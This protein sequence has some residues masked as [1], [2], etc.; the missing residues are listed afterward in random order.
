MDQE[1]IVYGCIKDMPTGDALAIK[2]RRGK[3]LAAILSL[4]A[5]DDWPYLSRNM[6]STPGGH[7][8]SGTY[9]TQIIHFGASY[10]AVEYEWALWIQKFEN[11]LKRMCWVS[12]VVHLETELSGRHTFL[13]E[14][15]G[16][17]GEL[18]ST[19]FQVRCEWQRE[20]VISAV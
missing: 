1:S 6:F 9:M 14:S 4:P 19:D 18:G 15:S 11:L 16:Q 20:G 2:K 12:V 17:Q 3:N 8:M 10:Q 13:W 5:D 7:V